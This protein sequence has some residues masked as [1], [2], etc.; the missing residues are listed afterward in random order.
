[1]DSNNKETYVGETRNISQDSNNSS[2]KIEE[3]QR[4]MQE[5]LDA[6]EQKYNE[7]ST[8]IQ[9]LQNDKSDLKNSIKTMNDSFQQVSKNVENILAKLDNI[10]VAS[11]D[12][13]NDMYD[14]EINFSAKKIILNPL[15]KLTIGAIGSV[16]AVIDKTSELTCGVKESFEDIVAEAQYQRKRKQMDT[17][18]EA[19]CMR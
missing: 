2:A 16:L 19:E 10:G 5:E 1:M 7:I 11:K 6:L 8:Q 4:K 18:D 14:R 13:D 15:R 17:V 3:V 9:E 12:S